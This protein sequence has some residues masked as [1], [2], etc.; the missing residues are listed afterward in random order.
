MERLAKLHLALRSLKRNKEVKR[1]PMLNAASLHCCTASWLIRVISNY[2]AFS[3]AEKNAP[4][5]QE[6]VFCLIN[7]YYPSFFNKYIIQGSSGHF[8]AQEAILK[9]KYKI[10]FSRPYIK[11]K[12]GASSKTKN[13]EKKNKK[14]KKTPIELFLR[15]LEP[16]SP[17]T[18]RICPLCAVFTETKQK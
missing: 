16:T 4:M 2:P 11:Q 13:Y 9:N 17:R 10:E 15:N 12:V 1:R 3:L 14:Q 7:E 8:A 18:L 6:I 5:R